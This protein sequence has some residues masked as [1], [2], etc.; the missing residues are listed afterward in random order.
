MKKRVLL[1]V[2]RMLVTTCLVLTSSGM[3]AAS[4][5]AWRADQAYLKGDFATARHLY[6]EAAV[7]I[8]RICKPCIM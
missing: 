3:Y 8:Q 4:F 1:L 6:E 7:L 5:N 2:S